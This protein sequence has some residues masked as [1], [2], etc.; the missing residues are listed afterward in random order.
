MTRYKRPGDL[1]SNPHATRTRNNAT[2]TQPGSELT[3][4]HNPELPYAP[5]THQ[6]HP[7]YMIRSMYKPNDTGIPLA[8]PHSRFIDR[9]CS[10]GMNDT[11]CGTVQSA[12]RPRWTRH[13]ALG[14]GSTHKGCFLILIVPWHVQ[15]PIKGDD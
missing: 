9:N 14:A 4:P 5:G 12:L 1:R 10:P 13:N 11:A 15:T 6:N 8:V 7:Q 3:N 2:R